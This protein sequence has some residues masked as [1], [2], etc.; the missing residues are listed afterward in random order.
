MG[1]VRFLFRFSDGLVRVSIYPPKVIH[2]EQGIS[3]DSPVSIGSN[4][5]RIGYQL[6]S[7]LWIAPLTQP[8]WIL[9]A[10]ILGVDSP[11]FSKTSYFHRV[12][13]VF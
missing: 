12:P 6:L 3:L 10:S 8:F 13:E 2:F 5:Q 11:F 9:I 1:R 7:N 4:Q